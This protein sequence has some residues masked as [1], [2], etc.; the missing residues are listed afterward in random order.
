MGLKMV[1]VERETWRSC[2]WR[3]QVLWRFEVGFGHEMVVMK[4]VMV[5]KKTWRSC[6]WAF[7]V[8]WRFE[9]YGFFFHW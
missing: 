4:M 3:F 6:K 2:R 8:L 9:L 1:M 5:E 7:Q